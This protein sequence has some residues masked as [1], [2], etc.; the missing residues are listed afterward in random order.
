MAGTVRELT[1]EH[2]AVLLSP[3]RW[4]LCQWRAHLLQMGR[5]R[6]V[7]AQQDASEGSRPRVS[8]LQS[9]FPAGKLEL[10]GKI[11]KSA[12]YKAESS[13]QSRETMR[14][15][16]PVAGAQQALISTSR[17]FSLH[18]RIPLVSKCLSPPSRSELLT[19]AGFPSGTAAPPQRAELG[20]LLSA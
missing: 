18:E 17:S 6:G 8:G 4:I 5:G 13:L 12:L 10:L 14:L 9:K 1:Q 3:P 11:S 16:V 15:V 7:L 20:R 19:V 2:L